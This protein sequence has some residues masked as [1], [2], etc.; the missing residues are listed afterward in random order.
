VPTNQILDPAGMQV[1][2][3][4]RPVDL[5]LI[6]DGKTLVVK[7]LRDLVIIDVASGKIK[8]TLTITARLVKEATTAREA[9]GGGFSVVGL[10]AIGDRILATD[11][12]NAVRIAKKQDDGSYAW[13]NPV[14]V[15]TPAVGGLA[16]PAGLALQDEGQ[17]WVTSTRGN[18]MQLL[19][20]TTGKVE[21]VVPVGVAP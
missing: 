7:N 2:F 20:L 6:D 10:I 11:V 5:V 8:Q 4:G 18:N 16:H 21:A 1:T 15:E 14:I 3:P 9:K 13:T 12:Q 17:V 19:D